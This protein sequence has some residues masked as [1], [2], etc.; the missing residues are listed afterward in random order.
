[1]DEEHSSAPTQID[2]TVDLILEEI[3]ANL[4]T[5]QI[6]E[7]KER[8]EPLIAGRIIETPVYNAGAFLYRARNFTPS[9]NKQTCIKKADLVYPPN[10]LAKLG[11]LN[12]NEQSI[13]YCSLHRESV[14]YELPELSAGDD[15]IVTFWNTN[16]RML[17]NNIGYTE[18]VF[19]QLGARRP[20]PKWGSQAPGDNQATIDL[21]QKLSDNIIADTMSKDKNREVHETLSKYFAQPV[22]IEDVYKYKL[23]TAIAELHLGNIVNNE[24]NFAGVQYPSVRMWTD[25][26]NLALLPWYVDRNLEFMKAV[27]IRIDEKTDSRISLTKLDTAK[28]FDTDGSLVWL[29][30]LPKWTMQSGQSFSATLAPGADTDGDYEFSKEGE[31]CHWVIT[32]K[33]TG[34]IV[35]P[36]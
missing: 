7:I 27:H 17:V 10:H 21:P 18:Y 33:E 6:D 8:L 11:R 12:R 26:D 16:Q 32:D 22:K 28:T 35:E 20:V 9:F 36:Q 4:G 3:E 30:R 34:E 19:Q 14:F 1:M 23:T 2:M 13:F 15:I 31:P 29:D 25:G 24:A 5:L